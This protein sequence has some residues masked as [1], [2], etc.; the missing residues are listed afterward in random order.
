MTVYRKGIVDRRELKL[1]L[2][3]RTLLYL[4]TDILIS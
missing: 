4:S 2:T 1:A 3:T